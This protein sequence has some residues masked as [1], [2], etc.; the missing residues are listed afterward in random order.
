MLGKSELLFCNTLEPVIYQYLRDGMMEYCGV[1]EALQRTESKGLLY[2]IGNGFDL[3]HGVRSSYYDFR[4]S[5]SP[6]NIVRFTLE[7]YIHKG[8]IWGD[9][10]NNLAYLD[11][12][13]LM[14]SIDDCLEDLDV[15]DEDD[16]SFSA[17]NFYAAQEMALDPAHVLTDE[18][19][20]KF[21]KWINSLQ[22]PLKN[23][24]LAPIIKEKAHYL[25][26]N[27]TDFLEQ[28]YRIPV[29]Q[30]KYIHG[31][32]KNKKDELILGHGH[33]IEEVFD[34]WY[35]ENKDKAE[36]QPIYHGKIDENANPIYLAYFLRNEE[37]GNWKSQMRYDAIDHA[38]GMLEDYYEM[39]AKKTN[40]VLLRNAAYFKSL[41]N[42]R[43]IIVIGHSLSK[44]DYPYF[45]KIIEQN[46]SPKD[47]RWFISF[48]SA[49]D[50]ERINVFMAYMHISQ[51]QVI[52]F[53]I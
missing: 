2:I 20:R 49:A 13:M 40:D 25:T 41:Y 1:V 31:S 30:I 8:D 28:I 4:D 5:M 34:E 19:P 38:C 33:D 42:V 10:E 21:R 26:F 29:S 18:M 16:D 47:V 3:M 7:T 23:K 24:L 44:V 27:Y 53:R 32:R 45:S 43:N 14:G 48:H 9:F 37:D 22:C 35:Q 15:P 46:L 12:A 11:R 52:R 17:A 6:N 39:S 36:Y 51:E 50:N